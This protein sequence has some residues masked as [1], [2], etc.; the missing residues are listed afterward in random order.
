MGPTFDFDVV[1]DIGASWEPQATFDLEH[2]WRVLQLLLCWL[3]G[4]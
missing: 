1:E 3:R 2:S 4:I